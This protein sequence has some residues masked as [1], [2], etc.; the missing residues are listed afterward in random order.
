MESLYPS[1]YHQIQSKPQLAASTEQQVHVESGRSTNRCY[2]Y[3]TS[4]GNSTGRGRQPFASHPCELVAYAPPDPRR[5]EKADEQNPFK[6]WTVLHAKRPSY[7]R[8]HTHGGATR[9]ITPIL[10]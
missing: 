1:W 4:P 5:K 2:Y 9:Q 8:E 6:F 7:F 10:S 3:P